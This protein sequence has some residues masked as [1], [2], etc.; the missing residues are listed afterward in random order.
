[1]TR[2]GR[3]KGVKPSPTKAKELHKV[4]TGIAGLDQ[5]LNGG[6]PMGRT[7]LISGGPGTGK[8]VIGMEFLYR[9]ALAGGRGIFITFEE[10]AG[11]LRQNASS[12]GWDLAPLEQADKLFL[13]EAHVDLKAVLSGDFD[14]KALFAIMEGKSKAMGANRMVIDA[15]D[16]LLRLFDE[17][18]RERNELY[19]LHDWLID[20]NLTT[21]LTV[22]A[23][24]DMATP[25][26]YEF[27]DF[28]A[29]CVIHL[30]QRITEQVS[31]RRLRVLKYRGSGFG[32]N[33]YPFV[34]TEGGINVIPL[35]TVG[36]KHKA[37]GRMVSS[38]HSRLDTVLGGGYHRA[39]C[40]LITGP[41]GTGKSTMACTF[42]RTA[43]ERGEKVLYIN[44]E[45]SQE[46]MVSCM[47][48]PGIDLRPALKA[49][50]LEI[51]TAMPESMGVEE[52]LIR[53]FRVME[54]FHPDHI[55][56]DAI[57]AC[58]RMSSER[59]AFDFLI[60]L[61]NACKE[62]GIMVMLTNQAAGFTER[63]EISGIG[64]S[65]AID[66]VIS[67]RYIQTGGEI[68][69]T[70]L[71][72]K[73]RGSKHSNQYREFLIT[74]HG[75]DIVDIYVGEGGVL[76][77]VARQEQEA[78]EAVERGLRE[79]EIERK[80]HQVIQKR[81][82]LEAQAAKLRG[83]LQAAQAEVEALRLEEGKWQMG[84]ED[85]GKMRHKDID[86][87]EERMPPAKRKRKRAG[88]KGG[89]K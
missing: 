38:G 41:S 10:R 81:A 53:I 20:H 79:Q 2:Q 40:N 13:L 6:F 72:M 47:L 15:L 11:A 35:T 22:K 59:A 25:A 56:V 58:K 65:S 29:D 68:N 48:S 80:E 76:T 45:E 66:T 23:S 1:M 54:A 88:R 77:G 62:Q 86:R 17:P 83:E 33:E 44:F 7:T 84:R 82:E 46:A 32:L 28:M 73:S 37:L 89:A 64:I 52:H 34:I 3:R 14:L 26:R 36:L 61:A 30:D 27:L 31:T 71:V 55:V 43:C 8:S 74:D 63:Q 39:S 75:I 4:P 69:R 18:F 78:R 19:L 42:V 12:M 50:V 87:A 57:S 85:R 60:R 51:L 49:G 70:L 16:V 24:K 67:L 5:V 9:S 21:L